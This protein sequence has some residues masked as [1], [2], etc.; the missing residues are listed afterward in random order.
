MGEF[1]SSSPHCVLYGRALS[2][3]CQ[4]SGSSQ[5]QSDLVGEMPFSSEIN[6]LSTKAF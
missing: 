5:I 4:E 3:C 6:D 2:A 1:M